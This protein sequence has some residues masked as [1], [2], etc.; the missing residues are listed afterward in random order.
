MDRIADVIPSRSRR[1]ALSIFVNSVIGLSGGALAALLGSFA[2][3]PPAAGRQRWLRAGSV[4]DLVPDVPVA[5]VL[6]A[7]A[8]DGWYR[9]RSRQTVFIVWDGARNVRAFSATCTHLGC[10]VDW[11]AA[12]RLFR[13]PCHGGAY[14][15]DGLVVAGP[16]PRPLDRVP[17]RLD[18]AG[19]IVL[20]ER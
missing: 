19:E 8:N 10:R 15:A 1:R 3:R 16:P 9:V 2:A 12:A 14:D 13:C 5:R 4:K 11:D 18:E 7:P 6:S 17:A 20:V